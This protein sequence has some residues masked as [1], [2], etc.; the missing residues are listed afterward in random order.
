MPG[1]PPNQGGTQAVRRIA[2]FALPALLGLALSAR[3]E[4]PCKTRCIEP[5]P[6]PRV[7]SKC[8]CGKRSKLCMTDSKCAHKAIDKLDADT[9]CQR[10]KA[11]KK[12]GCRLC[13]DFCRDPEV[14]EAL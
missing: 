6:P 2:I 14:L 11:A 3:A 12:L 9:C 13:A 4:C 1:Q 8:P 10:K 7:K 5:P